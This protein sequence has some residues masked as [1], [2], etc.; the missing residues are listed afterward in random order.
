MKKKLM[1]CIELDYAFQKPGEPWGST[2]K[3]S[4]PTCFLHF[5]PWPNDPMI[6]GRICAGFQVEISW[7]SAGVF[8]SQKLSQPG[9][10]LGGHRKI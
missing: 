7:P 3:T 1:H 10:F 2:I 8:F 4:Q 6:F 9:I 5:A